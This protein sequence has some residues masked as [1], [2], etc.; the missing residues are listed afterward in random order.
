M[1][2]AFPTT[3]PLDAVLRSGARLESV[4]I[5]K[6]GLGSA[7]PEG[8]AASFEN[9]FPQTKLQECF[10]RGLDHVCVVA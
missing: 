2:A 6:L 8:N 1:T 7:R 9:V 3:K 5:H 4:Q 10:E